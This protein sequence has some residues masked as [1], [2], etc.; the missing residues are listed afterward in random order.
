VSV[1]VY[2][3]AWVRARLCA[4]RRPGAASAALLDRCPPRRELDGPGAGVDVSTGRFER[5]AGP[6]VIQ[7]RLRSYA[8][9]L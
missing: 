7:A 8:V 5:R 6:V 3:D 4:G 2:R 9:R 1:A